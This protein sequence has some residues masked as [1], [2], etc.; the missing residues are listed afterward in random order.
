MSIK[1]V[2]GY[3]DHEWN[4]IDATSIENIKKLE[5]P[6]ELKRKGNKIDPSGLVRLK[7]ESEEHLE[8]LYDEQV[9]SEDY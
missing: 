6:S 5:I 2:V 8:N 3:D 9:Y 1:G 4:Y 7:E